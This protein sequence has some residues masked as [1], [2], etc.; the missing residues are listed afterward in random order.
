M[1]IVLL[2]RIDLPFVNLTVLRDKAMSE[3][4]ATSHNIPI[5]NGTLYALNTISTDTYHHASEYTVVIIG[6]IIL[7]GSWEWD[8]SWGDSS[9][10]SE[11]SVVVDRCHSS[12][13]RPLLL[14]MNI[15]RIFRRVCLSDHCSLSSRRMLMVAVSVSGGVFSMATGL[16]TYWVQ[17]ESPAKPGSP[18]AS[19][20]GRGWTEQRRESMPRA[21]APVSLGLGCEF[22][23][24]LGKLYR[25]R[26]ISLVIIRWTR[27]KN[28]NSIAHSVNV[29]LQAIYKRSFKAFLS[30]RSWFPIILLDITHLQVDL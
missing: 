7:F 6:C 3:K 4:V 11:S 1:N 30:C 16:A 8:S 26:G 12:S 14:P 25:I 10:S 15:P 2:F 20:T 27:I 13:A 23:F 22:G 19:M 9:S 29:C 18:A 5:H 17:T 24:I 28:L 21:V